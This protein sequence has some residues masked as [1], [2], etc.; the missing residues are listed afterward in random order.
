MVKGGYGARHGIVNLAARGMLRCVGGAA[1]RVGGPLLALCCPALA[2]RGRKRRP[3][4]VKLTMPNK[5]LGVVSAEAKSA[6]V[7]CDPLHV[8]HEQVYQAI[9]EAAEA[10][11]VRFDPD[12]LPRT[13]RCRS[14]CSR[15]R[16]GQGAHAF[17]DT[18]PRVSLR[19]SSSAVAPSAPFLYGF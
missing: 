13:S 6:G 11:R 3:G 18:R 17:E 12:G 7:G 2:E 1:A 14:G 16:D 9:I 5:V 15:Q 4:S 10:R 19:V 8:E